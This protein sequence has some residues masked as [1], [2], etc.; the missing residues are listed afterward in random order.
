MEPN[1]AEATASFPRTPVDHA[2]AMRLSRRP[3]NWLPRHNMQ[4]TKA[5]IAQRHSEARRSH[6]QISAY[7]SSVGHGYLSF[8]SGSAIC[9]R[10][11]F[12]LW[13]QPLPEAELTSD[14]LYKGN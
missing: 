13:L 8:V 1:D 14:E 5:G 2:S 10:R 11:A 4:Q 9:G 3:A 6:A 12:H 7:R